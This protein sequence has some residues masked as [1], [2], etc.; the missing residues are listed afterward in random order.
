M[1]A[2]RGGRTGRRQQGWKT[3]V[4]KLMSFRMSAVSEMDMGFDH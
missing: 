2:R 4:P 3:Y 1:I